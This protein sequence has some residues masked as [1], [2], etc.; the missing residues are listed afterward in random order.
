MALLC[1]HVPVPIIS[2]VTV[3]INYYRSI[4]KSSLKTLPRIIC[5]LLVL[6]SGCN[7]YY[8]HG[9]TLNKSMKITWKPPAW[10]LNW[11]VCHFAINIIKKWS[12]HVLVNAVLI[13]RWAWCTLPRSMW[14]FLV[15]KT[16]E[17]QKQVLF[18]YTIYISC[19]WILDMIKE[20][21]RAGFL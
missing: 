3:S 15:T 20:W 13:T 16:S 7:L 18:L 17:D 10:N 2:L 4:Q 8:S 9:V 5:T 11:I 21:W 14:W 6:S 19:T 12:V 1:I